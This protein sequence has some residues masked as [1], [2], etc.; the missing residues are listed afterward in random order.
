M[1]KL[2]DFFNYYLWVLCIYLRD[3]E[4][5]LVACM[6]GLCFRFNGAFIR[7]W[8]SLFQLYVPYPG[9]WMAIASMDLSISVFLISSRASREFW[10]FTWVTLMALFVVLPSLYSSPYGVWAG[11]LLICR[12]RIPCLS[13]DGRWVCPAS[14]SYGMSATSFRWQ[15]LNACPVSEQW[16]HTSVAVLQC[17][18]VCPYPWHL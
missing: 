5:C 4:I 12:L 8:L 9:S 11:L 1:D 16:P 10:A 17:F 18:E 3:F 13:L 7:H 6:F 15:A 14:Y 2:S